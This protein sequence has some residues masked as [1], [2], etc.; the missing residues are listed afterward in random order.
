MI[1]SVYV[2]CLALALGL[3]ILNWTFI[4]FKLALFVLFRFRYV[5]D[6]YVCAHSEPF[7]LD[8][9]FEHCFGS[10]TAGS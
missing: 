4:F 3:I 7:L 9:H 10:I 8:Y 2:E 5:G 6:F 1:E